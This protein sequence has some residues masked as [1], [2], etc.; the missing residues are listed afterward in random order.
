MGLG[1]PRSKYSR[2]AATRPGQAGLSSNPAQPHGRPL[3]FLGSCFLS[4]RQV[5]EQSPPGLYETED[6]SA[7][8]RVAW[9]RATHVPSPVSAAAGNRHTCNNP[10]AQTPRG[11]VEH[12]RASPT[13]LRGRENQS[14]E[15]GAG[16]QA[17]GFWPDGSELVGRGRE[18]NLVLSFSR[19]FEIPPGPRETNTAALTRSTANTGQRT[20]LR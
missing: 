12:Q 16:S 7:G 9:R 10:A 3:A 4:V 8:K 15:P 18:R 2:T 19:A 5:L 6:V 17:A 13:A 1:I 20:A 14:A 11:S